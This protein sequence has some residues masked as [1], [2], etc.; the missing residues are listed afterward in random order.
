MDI[1]KSRTVVVDS[2]LGNTSSRN[3][4]VQVTATE[5]TNRILEY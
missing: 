2:G 1:E 3:E 5:R 4:G